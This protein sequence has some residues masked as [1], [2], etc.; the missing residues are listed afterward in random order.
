MHFFLFTALLNEQKA[1]EEAPQ[2]NIFSV[3]NGVIE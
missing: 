2:I 3:N 1:K